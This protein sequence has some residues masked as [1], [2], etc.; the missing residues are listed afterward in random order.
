MISILLAVSWLVSLFNLYGSTMV[1]IP[2]YESMKSKATIFF[3]FFRGPALGVANANT[4]A[5]AQPTAG[6]EGENPPQTRYAE[7]ANRGSSSAGAFAAYC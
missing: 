4:G 1:N 2:Y 6:V 5:R 3:N 7:T